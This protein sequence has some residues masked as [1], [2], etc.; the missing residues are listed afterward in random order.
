MSV[1]VKR[2][3]VK[4]DI[5]ELPPSKYLEKY[6]GIRLPPKVAEFWDRAG[7]VSDDG[8]INFEEPDAE[9]VAG[10]WEYSAGKPFLDHELRKYLSWYLFDKD[11]EFHVY[12]CMPGMLCKVHE[13]NGHFDFAVY[14]KTGN[15]L[16]FTGAITGHAYLKEEN[17][18]TYVEFIPYH[19][20]VAPQGYV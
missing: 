12:V 15:K 11:P 18:K 20:T 8:S 7:Y 4:E 17:G 9:V 2:R 1:M 16:L 14:D 19:I 5:T 10:Y 6:F 13:D 3:K